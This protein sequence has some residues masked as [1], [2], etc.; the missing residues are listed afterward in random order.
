VVSVGGGE[1]DEDRASRSLNASE[2]RNEHS[3]GL[4]KRGLIELGGVLIS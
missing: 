2:R 4:G 3:L 1:E